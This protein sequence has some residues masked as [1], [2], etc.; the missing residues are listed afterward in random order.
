[1]ST[2]CHLAPFLGSSAA[3]VDGLGMVTTSF[4]SS[5]CLTASL[6]E[7][8]PLWDNFEGCSQGFSEGS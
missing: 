1:M 5:L 2:P 6:P 8:F 7:G 3:L 4:L